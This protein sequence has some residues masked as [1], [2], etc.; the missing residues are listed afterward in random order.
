MHHRH[1]YGGVKLVDIGIHVGLRIKGSL[2]RKIKIKM[3]ATL[4]F[5]SGESRLRK[6]SFPITV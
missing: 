4:Y 3:C 2:V 6:N 1:F 5:V